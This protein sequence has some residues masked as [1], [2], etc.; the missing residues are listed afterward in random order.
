MAT[1][2]GKDT[3]TR[4]PRWHNTQ[5]IHSHRSPDDSCASSSDNKFSSFATFARLLAA[6]CAASISA[7]FSATDFS[8]LTSSGVA[9]RGFLL[10]RFLFSTGCGLARCFSNSCSSHA[11]SV[12]LVVRQ[13]GEAKGRIVSERTEWHQVKKSVAQ[14]SQ[15]VQYNMVR[16]RGSSN[17]IRTSRLLFISL[18]HLLYFLSVHGN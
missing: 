11:I 10:G 13:H 7:T 14:A 17:L 16:S 18:I 9:A 4:V 8:D 15:I 5:H 2:V 3:N 12:Q 1:G 6:F